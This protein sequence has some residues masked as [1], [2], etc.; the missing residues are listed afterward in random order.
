MR[1]HFK[2]RMFE[3]FNI[4]YPSARLLTKVLRQCSKFFFNLYFYEVCSDCFSTKGKN[5]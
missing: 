5:K 4:E 1:F 2:K 3:H